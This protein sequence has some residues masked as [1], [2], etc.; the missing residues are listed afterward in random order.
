MGFGNQI[1]VLLYRNFL[2]KRRNIKQTIYEAVSV[3]YF[4]A[5]L[6]VVRKTAVKP[7]TD[8]PVLDPNLPTY[9]LY[10]PTTAGSNITFLPVKPPKEIGYV[11][12]PGSSTEQETQIIEKLKTATAIF[13]TK[14]SG[15]V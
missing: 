13:G 1:K 12:L 15:F 2:I 3:L 11:F 10:P 4:V 6:A 7:K 8:P 9:P 5:I 14:F